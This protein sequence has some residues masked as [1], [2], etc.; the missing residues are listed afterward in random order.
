LIGR[1]YARTTP[2]KEHTALPIEN[3]VA[4]HPNPVPLSSAPHA[5]ILAPRRQQPLYPL[6]FFHNSHNGNGDNTGKLHYIGTILTYRLVSG[7]C[8]QGLFSPHPVHICSICV[9]TIYMDISVVRACSAAPTKAWTRQIN[10]F[11][12]PHV[13]N[14]IH[15]IQHY[16]TFSFNIVIAL[17]TDGLATSLS[18]R[19]ALTT[20]TW[21]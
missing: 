17:Y 6:L 3:G 7:Y 18:P 10:A 19:L 5:S 2:L 21:K 8:G 15:Y 4:A 11:Y 1:G 20:F 13:V 12:S 16:E 14:K 9:Y